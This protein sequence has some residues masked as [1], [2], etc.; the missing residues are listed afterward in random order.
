MEQDAQKQREKSVIGRPFQP[1]ESGN[2]GGRPK[3]SVS[4]TTEIRNILRDNPDKRK[5]LAQSLVDLA[6]E[7][8]AAAI[9]EV[10]TRHDGP[11]PVP[12]NVSQL[13][14]EQLLAALEASLGGGG[15]EAETEPPD[16]D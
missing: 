16:A 7:G 9:R 12:I 8:N 3:G 15:E 2:P 11:V 13:S 14:N 5:Q 6:A 4:I 10:M 1:G